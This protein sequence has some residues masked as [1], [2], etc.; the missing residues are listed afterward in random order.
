MCL[1]VSV[2]VSHWS[3]RQVLH[4]SAYIYIYPHLFLCRFIILLV[5]YLI[6]EL[7]LF[8]RTCF[9]LSKT[10]FQALWA[11][12]QEELYMMKQYDE[13]LRE[14]ESF[15]WLSKACSVKEKKFQYQIITY[16]VIGYTVVKLIYLCVY[17]L[18]FQPV[19]S[20]VCQFIYMS[21]CQYHQVVSQYQSVSIIFLF[22]CLQSK[23]NCSSVSITY[24]SVCQSV[25]C[26]SMSV[27]LFIFLSCHLSAC[28]QYSYYE[29]H[30][31]VT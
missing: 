26:L 9:W 4:A 21:G 2:S 10:S 20:S 6:L 24:L 13:E 18:F 5:L 8:H 19:S 16:A 31:I 12:H 29:D 17:L 22:V 1:R 14:L 7:F 3:V 25:S 28:L 27:N 23:Y 30:L 11:L 15:L